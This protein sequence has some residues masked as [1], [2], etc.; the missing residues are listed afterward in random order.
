MSLQLQCFDSSAVAAEA[1]AGVIAADLGAALQRSMV[2]SPGQPVQPL[3]LVS[4]GR[5]PLPLFSALSQQPLAWNKV[6]VSLVDERCVAAS[7][8]DSNSALVRRHLLTGPAASAHWVALAPTESTDSDADA[9]LSALHAADAANRN[10]ALAAASVI[11]LGI[12]TD[13]HTASLFADAPQWS[14]ARTTNSRY[15]AMQ[16]ASAPH[17]RISLSLSALIAQGCCQVWAV[18]P[19]KLATIDRCSQLPADACALAALIADSRVRLQV[20]YSPS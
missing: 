13:G 14:Q 18:G 16:S 9:W 2:S 3:L 19:D 11:V 12:G 7:H 6:A 5:S 4:G 8:N 15:L 10:P 1:L 17:P 20:F